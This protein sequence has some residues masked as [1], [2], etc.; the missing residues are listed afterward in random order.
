MSRRRPG[1][2]RKSAGPH[3]EIGAER[4]VPELITAREGICRQ[5]AGAGETAAGLKRD[6]GS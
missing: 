5:A 2:P 3:Q 4:L 1:N 6:G